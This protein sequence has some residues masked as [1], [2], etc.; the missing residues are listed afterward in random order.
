MQTGSISVS[1]WGN[2][3]PGNDPGASDAAQAA[4]QQ[5]RSRYDR[6]RDDYESLLDRLRDLER[7]LA[8]E[9]GPG[10]EPSPGSRLVELIAEPLL[11]MRRE[12]IEAAASINTIVAGLDDIA[13]RGMKAQRSAR[14]A[15]PAPAPSPPPSTSDKGNS[16]IEIAV[17][18]GDFGDL[19]D[20]QQHLSSIERVTQVSIRSLDR[21]RATLVVELQPRDQA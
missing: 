15:A 11:Q 1:D 3:E 7:R 13:T 12:Y 14:D 8:S 2:D 10:S 18:G 4:L 19:L 9:P 20:F 16:E 5:L 21:D 17:E 6:L